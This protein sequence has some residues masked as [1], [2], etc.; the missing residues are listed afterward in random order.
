MLPAGSSV[1]ACGAN[2]KISYSRPER[3]EVRDDMRDRRLR[4]DG[5]RDR[6]RDGSNK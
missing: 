2:E 6:M 3:N 5:I 4:R 1:G